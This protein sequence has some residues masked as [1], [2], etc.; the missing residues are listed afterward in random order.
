MKPFAQLWRF[1]LV[2]L[3]CYVVNLLT[4]AALCE[5]MRINYISAFVIVFVLGNVLGYW[6]N[7]RFTF[8]LRQHFD[9]AALLRYLLINL[10]ILL[11]SM[12]ALHVLVEWLGIWY[13]AAVTMV[14]G[15]NAPISF[16]AH[17]LFTYR[18]AG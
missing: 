14:A 6:L 5:F 15:I 16:V 7:R 1:C 13:L 8:A 17:R 12:A 3:T 4:L 11:V 10:A 9:R 18:L 2:G